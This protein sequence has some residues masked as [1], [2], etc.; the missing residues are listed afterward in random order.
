[1]LS[2]LMFLNSRGDVVLSR[3]FRAGNTV[4]SLAETF[5]T[6]IIS[7]K[8][9]DRCPINIVKRVCFIHLKLT[10]LYVV[11]VSDSNANCLMCLQY[12][13]RLLQY[14]QKYYEDLNEKQIK[15]NFVALQS[16]IDES[17]DFGYPILTDAEAI[18]KFVTT[19]GVDAAVLKNTRESERIADRMTGET[20]WRVEG[21]VFR[22]NEVFIDVFEEVNLLLSQT[23]ETLQSSVSGRVVMNNFLSGM[24]ECQLHWN[25]KVMNRSPDEPTENQA[26]D[27]TGKL[28]PLSNISLHNCVRLKASGNEER[29]LTF[30]PPDGKF[31]LM[32]YRSSVSVQPP[33]KV[34]S[35]KAR[36]ISKTRT[37]VEFTLHS[38]APGGRVIRDV[39]VSVACPD[40][41]AIAEAK[42][43]QGKA[44]YDAVSHAIV[45]KLPQVKS[46]EKIAFFAEIQQ[47]SPTEKME[48]LWTKPPIR[49]AFQ[50]MSLSLTGLRINGLVVREP[51][52]MYTP[53]KWIRYTVMAGDYQCRM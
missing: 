46:G 50:C 31:T 28:V 22:V 51:T 30:V 29:Q 49:I 36:E 41:T 26:A 19:D 8:Q 13:V 5:C 7:T 11:M 44:D 35:A 1:M 17:M 2:V 40:N 39:Q 18:R 32:T 53:N 14:I 37:E 4:R 15:E 52:M 16:I 20:P 6:E 25:V 27:G 3:T 34:L 10:E 33:M 9:V 23:G 47:I 21:L 12:A 38:D 24:P 42:V 48:T 43:G 45:W